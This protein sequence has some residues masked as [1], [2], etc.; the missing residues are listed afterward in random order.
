M[1]NIR[2]NPK[3][4]FAYFVSFEKTH[5]KCPTPGDSGGWLYDSDEIVSGSPYPNIDD[6]EAFTIL[7]FAVPAG[8]LALGTAVGWVAKGF[9]S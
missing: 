5:P 7:A 9:K 2:D 3:M 1:Q 8:L 4:S 6:A